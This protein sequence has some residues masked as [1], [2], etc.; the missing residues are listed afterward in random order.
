[1]SDFSFR[2]TYR[3][4]GY[5]RCGVLETRHGTIQTPTFMPVGTYGAVRLTSVHEL[6]EAG[7]QIILGN[8]YHLHAT[9]GADRIHDLGGLARFCGWN[10][11][12]LTDSGG[13][14]V[15]YMWNSGT[16]SVQGGQRIHSHKSPIR[17]IT[18]DGALVKNIITGEEFLYGPEFAMEVQSKIGADI[19]MPFDQP[20]F[21]TD[22]YDAA[23][24][25][26]ERS[27]RWTKRSKEHWEWLKE[28]GK[29]PEYQAFFPIIQGGRHEGLR[30]DS[31]GFSTSIAETGIAIAGESIG[32]DPEISEQTLRL[33]RNLLPL[34]R[35]LYAMGLGGGPEG[36]FRGVLQGVDMF[37]NTS[38]TRLG[39]CGLALVS[40]EGGSKRANRF[41]I[42]L[43]QSQHKSSE[44]PIDEG[45]Q[46]RVCRSH[47]RAYIH[48]LLKIGESLGARLICFHNVYFMHDLGR[49]I[50]NAIRTGNLEKLYERWMLS[51]LLE[52]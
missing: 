19:V 34:D 23:S 11:P 6:R 32:I 24:Q 20:T 9:A 25:T 16:H 14:Q 10:G 31:A 40:P 37:D 15:S 47:S 29:A 45:C 39:R 4:A 18:E 3:S 35:P 17:K 36:F 52:P 33:V 8:A 21:D 51:A 1:M 42:S 13:Y 43:R 48:H 44:I 27:H 7:A 46:C 30:R 2:V 49:A 12:T 26:L 50:Q 28:K 22:D 5:A 38:P 41:R